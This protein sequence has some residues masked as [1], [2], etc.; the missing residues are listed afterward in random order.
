VGLKGSL[1][2]KLDISFTFDVDEI[3]LF[4]LSRHKD[5]DL[6]LGIDINVRIIPAANVGDDEET[7][8]AV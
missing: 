1:P 5:D 8:K 3:D 7:K 6:S 4:T 2:N